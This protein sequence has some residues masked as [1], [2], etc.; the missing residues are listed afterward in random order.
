MADKVTPPKT[1]DHEVKAT[2]KDEGDGTRSLVLRGR[3]HCWN[4]ETG[5][6]EKYTGE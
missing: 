3:M 5:Q 2:Y 4:P 1:A 6:W